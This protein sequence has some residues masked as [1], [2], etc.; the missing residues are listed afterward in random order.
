M[1]YQAG[2]GRKRTY[3][4]A[5]ALQEA[6]D[7]YFES[8]TYEKIVK[9]D[10]GEVVYNAAGEPV[11]RI[12]FAVPPT[13]EGL[14][15]HIGML[16]QR[17]SEYRADDRYRDVCQEADL[18]I[19]AWRT[20]EVST[21]DRTQGLQFLLSNDS[22]MSDNVNVNVNSASMSDRKNVLAKLAQMQEDF[23]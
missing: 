5:E 23:V 7:R 14:C 20:E 19:R 10:D 1:W 21:R 13:V 6:V 18:K 11:K 8:I 12:A 17:W 4:T 15:L 3:E 16:R 22:G 2:P 9:G